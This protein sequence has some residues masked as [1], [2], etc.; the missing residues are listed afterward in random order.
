MPPLPPDVMNWVRPLLWG[1]VLFVVVVIAIIFV[2]YALR[3]LK[4]GTRP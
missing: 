4:A 2:G 3:W 1:V